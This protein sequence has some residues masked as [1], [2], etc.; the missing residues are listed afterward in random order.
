MIPTLEDRAS[1]D[2]VLALRRRWSADLYPALA[3][4]AEATATPAD[5]AHRLPIYPWFAW[6]ERGSQKM[7]WRAASDSI[8]RRVAG[9]ADESPAASPD[10]RGM[11]VVPGAAP[12]LVLDPQLEL[13]GWYTEWDIHVQPGGLAA[14]HAAEV[15]ELGAKLV[16]MGENDDY[17]FH[18]L[19]T[20]TAIPRRVYRQIVDLG[21]GFG[22]STWPLARA[23]P[24]AEVIGVDLSAPCLRMAAA[25]TRALGLPN[26]RF[27]QAPADATGLA[28]GSVDLVTS[29]M[30]IHEVPLDVLAG[31]FRE[32]ARLLAPGG[33]LRFLDFQATGDPLRD[34]ALVEHGARNNEPFLPPMLAADLEAMA[35]DAGFSA[36][37][38]VAFD[39]RGAGRLPTLD[40]PARPEWHFPWA[41]IEAEMP[42]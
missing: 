1:L 39:E 7:L 29:T 16:M 21:C 37:R 14:P 8:A 33:L 11:A 6:I 23:Y 15:Y 4:Q 19:F 10:V 40:W 18:R 12:L 36:C 28:D 35:R 22:K 13:P 38:R 41:V 2:F 17:R 31:V 34:R 42:A 32:A 20:E 24:E 27:V 30:L 9:G 3:A 25:R 5:E 26:L